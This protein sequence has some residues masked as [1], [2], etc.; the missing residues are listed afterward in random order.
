MRTPR[1]QAVQKDEMS[2]AAF[3]KLA[4]PE[5]VEEGSFITYTVSDHASNEH[6]RVVELERVKKGRVKQL[7]SCASHA[8]PS[9]TTRSS[10]R[11]S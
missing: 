10:W 4:W 11:R 9:H 1:A 8:P 3:S 5:P 2:P 6:P 7:A